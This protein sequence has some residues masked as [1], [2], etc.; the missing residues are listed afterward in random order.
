MGDVR[1]EIFDE[2]YLYFSEVYL[3][4]ERSDRECSLIAELCS[5]STGASVLDVGCGHGRI[6]NRLAR[7]GFQVTGVD[8]SQ[9]ALERA[10]SEA[11][12]LSVQVEYVEADFVS[13]DWRERFDCVVSWYTSFGLSDDDRN[14][15]ILGGMYSAVKRGGVCL[16]EHINRDLVLRRSQSTLVHERNGQFMIDFIEFDPITSR[17]LCTRKFCRGDQ[18]RI[19]HYQIRLFTFAELATWMRRAGFSEVRGYGR[20]GERFS[21]QSERMIAVATKEA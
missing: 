14:C 4:P 16:I 1:A 9:K 19:V 20:E 2:D 11:K 10:R 6:A 18:V 7:M 21:L 12:A 17:L 15:G 3:T 5:L 13:L 8:A